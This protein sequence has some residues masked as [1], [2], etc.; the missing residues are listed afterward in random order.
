MLREPYV[1]A[2]AYRV[3]HADLYCN[4]GNEHPAVLTQQSF[5]VR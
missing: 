2:M 3:L 5:S 4:T 1:P